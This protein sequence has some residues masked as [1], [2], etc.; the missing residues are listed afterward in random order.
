MTA[1]ANR[2]EQRTLEVLSSLSYRTGELKRYLQDITVGVSELLQVD[3]SVVTVCQADSERVLASSI[4]LGEAANQVYALHGSLTGTVVKTGNCLIVED[5]TVCKDYGEAPEGYR[6]YLGVPLRT[7]AAVVI[8]TICSFNHQPRQFTAEEVQLAQ[9]FANRAGIA[10]DNYEL[11]QQQERVNQQLQEMNQQLQAQVRERQEVEQALR[12]SEA[13]FRALVEQSVDAIF[14]LDPSG[15][16]LD[17]N[18][19]ALENLGYTREELLNLSAPAVQKQ[20][21]VGGF[22]AAWARMAAGEI[23]VVDGIHQRQ[24]GT[25]FP[26]EVRSGAVEWEGRQVALAIARDVTDR[27]QADDALRQ[28]EEK[29]RQLTENM[30]QVVWMYAADGQPLYLSPAFES[31]WAQPCEVWYNNPAVWWQAIHPEDQERVR[32]A[33]Y[34]DHE[35]NF[36]EEY[37]IIRPDGAVRLIRDQAF[38]IRDATGHICRIAGIAEDVTERKQAEQVRLKAISALAEV[39][40]LAAMIVHELR[41]PLTTVLMGLNAI[42]RLDFPESIQERLNLALDEAERIRHLLREILL[43]AKPQALQPAELELNAW[44]TEILESI[45]TLPS[46]LNR[47]VDLIPARCPVTVMGDSD[48]LKQV[49]IN[50]VDNACEAIADGERVT[51][52]IEPDFLAHQVY[53]RVHNGGAA[54]APEVLPKLTRPFYTT[55]PTGTGL[56]LAIV[57]RIVDAHGG[58]LTITSSAATG[59]IASVRLAI[60]QPKT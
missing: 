25:T 18:P 53:I 45:R 32:T 54:I 50:L 1:I 20:L 47:R 44:M 4:D 35:G 51:W 22:A 43:Y 27:K 49:F 13:R 9:I 36:E 34:Q 41:N 5:A 28:S 57:K 56:G 14:V 39:G 6:A 60:A 37:R 21:P 58:D 23:V 26:V 31:I 42:K 2:P 29:F 33:F 15:K 17:A 8:G 40:E 12:E 55:K 16:F 24:D 19:R 30:H 7:P 48:K 59:T 3:W 52:S 38:P 11:Y 10:I 46:A